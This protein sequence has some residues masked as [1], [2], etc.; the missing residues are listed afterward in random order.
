MFTL[1]P[2][3][4]YNRYIIK[5]EPLTLKEKKRN[6]LRHLKDE[7]RK[8]FHHLQIH[9]TITIKW[10]TKIFVVLSSEYKDN[11][12]HTIHFTQRSHTWNPYTSRI[13]TPFLFTDTHTPLML[14][15]LVTHYAAY[16]NRK[17]RTKKICYRETLL[18]SHTEYTL[19]VI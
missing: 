15:M 19:L 14:S 2:H 7:N 6:R 17:R 12:Y 1:I 18:S 8:I 11:S 16:N 13:I 9:F 10:I 4:H 3:L 5:P